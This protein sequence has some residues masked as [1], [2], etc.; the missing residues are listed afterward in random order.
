[1]EVN[2]IENFCSYSKQSQLSQS[3]C[4]T[5][6]F[7]L[8]QKVKSWDETRAGVVAGQFLKQNLNLNSIFGDA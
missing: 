3:S 1:M 8:K 4:A 6:K 5:R 7:L 2:W